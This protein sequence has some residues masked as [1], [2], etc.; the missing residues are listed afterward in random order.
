MYMI[1]AFLAGII[2][3]VGVGLLVSDFVGAP[4]QQQTVSASSD[5][6]KILFSTPLFE[7]TNTYI[8]DNADIINFQLTP[9]QQAQYWLYEY[10][11]GCDWCAGNASALIT[12]LITDVLPLQHSINVTLST[13]SSVILMSRNTGIPPSHMIVQRQL[14][15]TTYN[16]TELIGPDVLEI[17]LWQ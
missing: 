4:N 10:N 8:E 9:A 13:N 7:L 1:D 17:Y 15:L 12:S 16:N 14:I 6:A 5:V 2:L 3:L 11:K